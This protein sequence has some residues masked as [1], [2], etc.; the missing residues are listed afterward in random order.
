MPAVI[1]LE[2][3]AALGLTLVA[4]A[5]TLLVR[6]LI[7]SP[8]R[9]SAAGVSGIAVIGGALAWLLTNAAN[10]I[11]VGLNAFDYGQTQFRTQALSWWN[12]T[13]AQTAY[14]IGLPQRTEFN[15]VAA[16]ANQALSTALYTWNSYL[17][18]LKAR[19]DGNEAATSAVTALAQFMWY[20]ALPELR[21]IDA[22][23]RADVDVATRLAQHIWYND[24]PQIRGIEAG[25]RTDLNNVTRSMEQLQTQVL[26]RV[27][28]DINSRA[29]QSDL[30]T[31]RDIVA[32][33][34][35]L[36]GTLA[37]LVP[38]AIA[39]AE[40]VESL[41]C[42]SRI[43]CLDWDAINNGDL[44]SLEARVSMLEVGGM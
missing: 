40:A 37:A 18:W 20:D 9:A 34:A 12:W 7:V 31:L 3:I 14:Y 22:G 28:A 35:A 13:V 2:A 4:I 42:A 25:V 21:G 38:L 16:N 39:G 44:S 36:L 10:M 41:R 30:L 15:A 8:L 24:L 43:G 6:Q 5:A 17:P 33:Q 11:E 19:V 26:P 1:G 32:K 23:L 29:L 27:Q